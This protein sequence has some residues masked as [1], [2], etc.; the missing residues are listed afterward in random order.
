MAFY[1]EAT[2]GGTPTAS[3]RFP[4]DA[5][6]R[7]CLVGFGESQPTGTFGDYRLWVTQTNVTR[8]TTRGKQSNRALDATF[9]YGGCRVVYNA[10]TLYSGSPWHTPG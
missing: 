9:V 4:E 3:R 5:P 6:A 10:G 7:E 1:L 8:W 2:D